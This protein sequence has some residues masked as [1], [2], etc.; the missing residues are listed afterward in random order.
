VQIGKGPI[1]P[2]KL[3]TD[4]QGK[5]ILVK[6]PAWLP[7]PADEKRRLR[8]TSDYDLG[9]KIK[10]WRDVQW[11]LAKHADGSLDMIEF[12]GHGWYDAAKND[13]GVRTSGENLMNKNLPKEVAEMINNKL[14]KDGV[15]AITTCNGG[16]F[17]NPLKDW[18]NRIKRPIVANTGLITH[19][20]QDDGDPEW[21][22]GDWVIYFPEK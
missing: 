9:G 11:E 18:A 12:E 19:Y 1:D 20:L 6:G 10:N 16:G 17:V 5:K 7:K 15:V 3:A 13:H 21:G 4:W 22:H 2:S 8:L 14:S